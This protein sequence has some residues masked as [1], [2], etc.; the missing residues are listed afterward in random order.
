MDK[1]LT[2]LLSYDRKTIC[3]VYSAEKETCLTCGAKGSDVL[4][5]CVDEEIDDEGDSINI[6]DSI[7]TK[8]IAKINSLC[9]EVK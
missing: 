5:V 2:R 6:M 7:C 4:F 3:E 8:C 9:Q 1:K